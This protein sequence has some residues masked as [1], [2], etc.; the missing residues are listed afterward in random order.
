MDQRPQLTFVTTTGP[1]LDYIGCKA[2]RRHTTKANF[3]RR[4]WQMV[5]SYAK[6]RKHS[7][8]AAGNQPLQ[9]HGSGDAAVFDLGLPWFGRQKLTSEHLFLIEYCPSMNRTH[10]INYSGSSANHPTV[11]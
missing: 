1:V 2:V 8:A 6:R 5:Q 11:L 4:R 7:V 10:H 3:K 9:S